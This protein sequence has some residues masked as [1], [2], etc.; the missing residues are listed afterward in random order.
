MAVPIKYSLALSQRFRLLNL[1]M[2]IQRRCPIY[3]VS[4][5]SHDIHR[6]LWPLHHCAGYSTDIPKHMIVTSDLDPNKYETISENILNHL[7]DQI[8]EILEE[9]TDSVQTD[10][11]YSVSR[12]VQ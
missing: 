2:S 3:L 4:F 11:S 9:N 10:C 8:E 7:T 12:S 5:K 6:S 1:I